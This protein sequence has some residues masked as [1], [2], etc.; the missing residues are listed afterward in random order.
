MVLKRRS[1]ELMLGIGLKDAYCWLQRAAVGL[2]SVPVLA[3]PRAIVS[4]RP[5]LHCAACSTPQ[6]A[7]DKSPPRERP[8]PRC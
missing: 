3:G 4:R 8:H 5:L 6:H 1:E 2:D 7:A